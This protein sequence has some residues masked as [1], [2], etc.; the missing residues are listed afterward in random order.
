MLC[1]KCGKNNAEVHLV[2]IVNGERHDEY[3]CRECARNMLP[4]DDVAKLMKMTFSFE[5]VIDMNEALKDLLF[6]A[7]P[8]VSDES[9]DILKC[10]YCG[11]TMPETLSDKGSAET[12]KSTDDHTL[13]T[14]NDELTDLKNGLALAVHDERY[15]D[16]AVI[17]DR[18]IELE[19]NNNRV[20][21]E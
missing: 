7:L 5:G 19:K 8:D 21:G 3:V 20:K 2:K 18:I 1:E 10:P 6:P 15:E 17:R 4:F 16:A 11:G 13:H 14:G 9:G 12:E